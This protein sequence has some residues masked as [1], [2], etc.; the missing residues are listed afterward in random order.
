MRRN[1]S[2]P[3]RHARRVGIAAALWAAAFVVSACND[4]N[5]ATVEFVSPQAN[6]TASATIVA[7]S[8]VATAT[9]PLT[10]TPTQAPS[11]SPT[12]ETFPAGREPAIAAALAEVDGLYVSPLTRDACLANNP[13]K[14]VCVE[15]KSADSTVDR[16]IAEFAGGD[17]EGGGFTFYMG[18]NAG[19]QW[20]FWFGTQQQ[21]YRLTSLP[22]DV[23]VCAD[24][25]GANVREQPQSGAASAGLAT[26]LTSLHAVEFVLTSPGSFRTQGQP[27]AGW[28][29]VSGYLNGWLDAR[30]ETAAALGSCTLRDAFEGTGSVG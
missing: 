22:G 11:P 26:D 4:G 7:S 21:S 24:G 20:H 10:E 14:R 25:D 12:P 27:G 15:L 17:P 1:T 13:Q 16:G 23:L 18:R 6:A 29:R 2:S 9:R 8:P 28:Y 3:N 5:E 30:Y 19:G